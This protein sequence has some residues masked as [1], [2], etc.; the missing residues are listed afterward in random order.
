MIEKRLTAVAKRETS[1]E[2]DSD[3]A[4][5]AVRAEGDA[6]SVEDAQ[7]L[8]AWLG[9]DMRRIGAFARARAM[10]LH[11]GRVKALGAGF[12]PDIYARDHGPRQDDCPSPLIDD[13]DAV[14][15]RPTRRRFLI[16]GSAAAAAGVV[17]MVGFSWQAAA[18]TYSTKRGEIRRVPLGD[19]SSMTLN[20]ET[21]ARVR[22]TRS[23]RHVQLVTGEALFDVVRDADRPFMVEVGASTLKASAT[24]FSVSKLAGQAVKVMVR[25]GSVELIKPDAPAPVALVA[26]NTR[27]TL[28][29]AGTTLATQPVAPAEIGRELAWQQGMLS[30]EDAPRPATRRSGSTILRSARRRSPGFTPPTTRKGS[31]VR[32]R[33]AW[34]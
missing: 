8:E 1:G 15:V 32:R 24:S 21:T 17:G 26:A 6:L 14:V 9:E 4:L 5:W 28:P 16:G 18:A 30:F 34:A 7:T 23:E 25:T 33:S 2:I 13:D 31:R 27:A 20:T 3:A 22:F 12:E 19:G 10:L 29:A 11:A